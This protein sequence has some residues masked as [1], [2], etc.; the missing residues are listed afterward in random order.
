MAILYRLQYSLY[1]YIHL[2]C[3][4]AFSNQ[5][6]AFTLHSLCVLQCGRASSTIV[7]R[8]L[9]L[10]APVHI[11]CTIRL[12][13]I[14]KNPQFCAWS[15]LPNIR[16]IKTDSFWSLTSSRS[17]ASCRNPQIPSRSL[18]TVRPNVFSY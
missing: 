11:I 9:G 17:L 2:I 7:H 3:C 14:H 5:I 13:K 18:T 10:Y 8:S 16:A 12:M 15:L 6:V 1:L 4:I